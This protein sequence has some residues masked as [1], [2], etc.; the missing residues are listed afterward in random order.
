MLSK[1][2]AEVIL[3]EWSRLTNSIPTPAEYGL[4][5]LKGNA[6]LSF[7]YRTLESQEARLMFMFSCIEGNQGNQAWSSGVS[8]EPQIFGL[9]FI[10]GVPVAAQF[11]SLF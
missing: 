3:P 8:S 4:A 2:A 7:A 9:T 11:S 6:S 10:G 1:L 5:K